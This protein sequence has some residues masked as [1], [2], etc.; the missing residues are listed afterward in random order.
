MTMTTE[1]IFTCS[2]PSI[3]LF[4]SRHFA[5]VD[6]Y[7][8]CIFVLM[9][10]DAFMYVLEFASNLTLFKI[11]RLRSQHAPQRIHVYLAL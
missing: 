11:I 2:F 7:Y 10:C 5:A 6:A 8:K 3:G 9:F 1:P 4:Y